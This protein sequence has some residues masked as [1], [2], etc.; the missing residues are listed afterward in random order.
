MEENK[1]KLPETIKP[2]AQN[3]FIIEVNDDLIKSYFFQ[4]YSIFWEVN[5]YRLNARVVDTE[6]FIID[7]QEL[8]KITKIKIKLL[9]HFGGITNIIECDVSEG[10]FSKNGVYQFDGISHTDL[11]FSVPENGF[12]LLYKNKA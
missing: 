10:K 4:S 5:K 8:Y 11:F 1:L 9:N 6:D 3:N 2:L 12:K 7:P